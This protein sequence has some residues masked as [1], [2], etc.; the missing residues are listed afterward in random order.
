M[1][2]IQS[3]EKACADLSGHIGRGH[4]VL[5]CAHPLLNVNKLSW[6]PAAQMGM[7]KSQM[8]RSGSGFDYE[9]GAFRS[10]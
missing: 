8:H 5:V 9:R 10:D 7:A 6:H 2:S 3:D 1:R 4:L